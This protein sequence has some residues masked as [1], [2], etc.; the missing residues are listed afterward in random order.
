MVDQSRDSEGML[1]RISQLARMLDGLPPDKAKALMKTLEERDPELAKK[2]AEGQF[3]FED[4][5]YADDRGMRALLQ[6]VDRSRV[7]LALR[8][9]DDIVHQRFID[10]LSKNAAAQLIDDIENTQPQRRSDVE[11]ARA[12][13]M[14]Q[15][16]QLK[17]DGAL[18][19]QRPG[20]REEYV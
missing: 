3:T 9:A 5:R 19:L 12:D 10:N 17:K 18:I 11:A 20:S 8:G 7:R 13:I 6:K 2:L 1:K 15:A 4:L 16:L 14:R